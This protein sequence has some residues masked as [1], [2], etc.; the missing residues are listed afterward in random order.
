MDDAHADVIIASNGSGVALEMPSIRD[1][2]SGINGPA[3]KAPY[4][5]S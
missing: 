3:K 5:S 2:V 4:M 1:A